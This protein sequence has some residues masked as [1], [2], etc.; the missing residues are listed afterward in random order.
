MLL[1]MTV[2]TELWLERVREHYLENFIRH[3]GSKV[4]LVV[5]GAGTGKSHLLRWIAA[6][7]ARMDY[8]TVFLS[9]R[10]PDA[11]TGDLLRFSNIV[12]FYK[13]V[14]KR[15]DLNSLWSGVCTRVVRE[16]GYKPEDYDFDRPIISMLVERERLPIAEAKR[17]L[18]EATASAWSHCGLSLAF[19]TFCFRLVACR[20]ESIEQARADLC[21][22]WLSGEK[23]DLADARRVMLFERL[24]KPNARV[25]LYSLVRMLTLAGWSGV[26]VLIDDLDFLPDG[27]NLQTGRPFYTPNQCKDIWE[28]MR[29][30][31]DEG[32][33]LPHLFVVL[34]GRSPFIEDEKK[35]VKS[36]EALWMRL[37][38]G[39]APGTDFNPWRDIVDADLLLRAL[40]G[41][42]FC[43]QVGT[44]L[45]NVLEQRGHARLY[46]EFTPDAEDSLLR[47]RVREAATMADGEV[48]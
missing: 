10:E 38:S 2:G 45:S 23:L 11:E 48:A 19:V 22:R 47:Q 18:S 36:Y 28:S 27:L 34:G 44:S 20:G 17:R 37:Q 46:K 25:W 5:G 29:Q 26:V 32:E 30:L 41:N 7:A 24:S 9:L 1:D 12:E 40:G 16:L 21:F 8:A 42:S 35:G 4:K 43:E 39:L 31:I 15:L 6:T 33:K 14:A 13:A 3:G